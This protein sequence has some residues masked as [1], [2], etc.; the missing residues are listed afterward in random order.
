MYVF[1]VLRTTQQM[2]L[3]YSHLKWGD[4]TQKIQKIFY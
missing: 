1:E 3:K 4:I 2:F